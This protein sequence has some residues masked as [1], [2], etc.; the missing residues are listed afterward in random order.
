LSYPNQIDWE[1]ACLENC[2]LIMFWV[3]RNLDTMPAFTTNIEFGEWM[4]KD[5]LK[6]VYGRPDD[7]PNMR[8][9]DYKYNKL[10]ETNYIFNNLDMLVKFAVRYLINQY[11]LFG[12]DNPNV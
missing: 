2:G 12:D 4:A 7:A 6:V 3:P 8:Y 5:P 1:S 11:A 10:L 9:M